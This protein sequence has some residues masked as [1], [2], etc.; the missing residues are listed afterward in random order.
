MPFLDLEQ[1]RSDA[2][3]IELYEFQGSF[4]TYRLTSYQAQVTAAGG[5]FVPVA[6]LERGVLKVGTQEESSL[7]LD[8][9]LPYDH[10]LV[11]EYAYKTA[12]PRLELTLYRVH[13]G[14]LANAVTMW[15]GRVTSFSVEGRKAKFRVPSQFA[16]ILQGV[17]PQPRFQAPCNHL[18]Y[19]TRCG[20][21]KSANQHTTTVVNIA[22]N[23]I[24]LD[25]HPY[26]DNEC[27]AG[28]MSF[29]SGNESRMIISH[30]GTSFTVS[31]PF[32]GLQVGAFVSI[33]RGCDHSFAT[34]KSKFSN[35]INFGGCPLV[36][37]RNPFISGI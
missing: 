15:K 5:T 20:V 4:T 18:L 25:S 22:G 16:Y 21:N 1:S 13:L 2:Q 23:V 9:T 3:P 37:D 12:P 30:V 32:A 35:G 31:Y 28:E 8:I 6:G 11:A 17:T 33:T 24:Q 19:D 26:A 7:A 29:A 36:P 14:D 34:C 27:A 10:P